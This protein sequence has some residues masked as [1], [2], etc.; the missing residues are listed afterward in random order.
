M[1]RGLEDSNA[2]TIADF[3]IFSRDAA[4]RGVRLP[5]VLKDMGSSNSKCLRGDIDLALVDM[6]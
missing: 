6:A 4:L 1:T 3:C 5:G 2:S